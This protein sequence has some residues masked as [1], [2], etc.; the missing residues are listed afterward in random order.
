MDDLEFR[1]QPC[2]FNLLK[3]TLED[4]CERFGYTTE[5]ESI[6]ECYDFWLKAKITDLGI[7]HYQKNNDV[8]I[9]KDMALP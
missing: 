7:L 8:K 9:W 1:Y 2:H 3:K 5:K 6:V 4:L